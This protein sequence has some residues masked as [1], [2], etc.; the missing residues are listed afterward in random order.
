[1]AKTDKDPKKQKAKSDSSIREAEKNKAY[2]KTKA[3][4]DSL[5]RE[6]ERKKVFS[7]VQTKIADAQIKRGTGKESVFIGFDRVTGKPMEMPSAKQRLE[8]ANNQM[9]EARRDSIAS[10]NLMPKG[11]RAA[12]PS[13][14]PK[15]RKST[16]KR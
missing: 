4:S 8:M 14:M 2:A 11:V 1:M 6:S 7:K 15:P 16:K 12:K 3:K 5:M 13:P 10:V 9:R